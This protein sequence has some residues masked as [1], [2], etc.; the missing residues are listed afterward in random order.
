M[1]ARDLFLLY[2]FLTWARM[3]F[4]AVKTIVCLFTLSE[5]SVLTSKADTCFIR[6]GMALWTSFV[7]PRQLNTEVFSCECDEL[8]DSSLDLILVKTKGL[9]CVPTFNL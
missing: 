7:L 3:R 2:N 4:I 1:I 6:E 8:G 5:P 9:N